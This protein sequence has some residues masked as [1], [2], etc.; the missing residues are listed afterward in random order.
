MAEKDGSRRGRALVDSQ[1]I[2]IS[3]IHIFRLIRL[4]IN[5]MGSYPVKVFQPDGL[6]CFILSPFHIPCHEKLTHTNLTNK[7][8][9]WFHRHEKETHGYNK[10]MHGHKM[11][12]P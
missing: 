12:I 6:P 9:L 4:F 1:H 5:T 2:F 7:F 11:K 3:E 8:R 10:K